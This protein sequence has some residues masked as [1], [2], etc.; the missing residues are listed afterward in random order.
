MPLI[1][2]CILL[3]GLRGPGAPGALDAKS[4]VIF[5][6]QIVTPGRNSVGIFNHVEP[7]IFK[8]E[9]TA[10]SVKSAFMRASSK[11]YFRSEAVPD[12]SLLQLL[13]CGFNVLS[14]CVSQSTSSVLEP[15]TKV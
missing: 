13:I 9:D 11:V 4:S 12:L 8:I 1:S 14:V 15:F 10:A 3:G 5:Q 7:K 2:D 6:Q